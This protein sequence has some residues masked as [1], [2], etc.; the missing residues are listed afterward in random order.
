[1]KK[2]TTRL[3]RWKAAMCLAALTAGTATVVQAQ[4]GYAGPV[5]SPPSLDFGTVTSGTTSAF[6]TLTVSLAYGGTTTEGNTFSVDSV[7]L[8]PGFI[9][10]GGSCPAGTAPSP[11]TID[12]AFQPGGPGAAAGDV[13]ITATSNGLQGVT[14]V[15]VTGNGAAFQSVPVLSNLALLIMLAGLGGLGL[16]YARRH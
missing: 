5:V 11:C 16:M 3:S 4:S 6:Q 14:N 10:T 8:P 7:A 2:K 9:R 12:I 15:P 1:M 13:A